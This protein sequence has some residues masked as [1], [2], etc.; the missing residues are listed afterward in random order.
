MPAM[1]PLFSL[2]Y[3]VI[4]NLTTIKLIAYAAEAGACREKAGQDYLEE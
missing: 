3:P 2:S 4:N 1:L